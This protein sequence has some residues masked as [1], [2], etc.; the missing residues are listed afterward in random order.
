MAGFITELKRRNVFR[1]A[2]LYI[3]GAWLILQIADVMLPLFELPEWGVRATASILALGFI[4]A[5]I[6]SWIY[7]FT[8]KGLVKEAD[9]ELGSSVTADSGRKIDRITIAALMSVIALLLADRFWPDE[10]RGDETVFVAPE[11][12]AV[13]GSGTEFTP[14]VDQ[15]IPDQ[16]VAVL[17]F[18]NMSADAAN[19][20]FA[21]GLS[22]TLLHELAQISALKVPA[23]T[24][25]FA[26]KGQD[27]DV[28][29]IGRL[30]GVATVLEGSVQKS[31]NQV[32]VIVQLVN[33]TDGSHMWSKNFD[34]DME[35]I[36]AIQDEIALEVC[37]ALSVTLL[38]SDRHRL[39]D[40][41]TVNLDAYEALILGQQQVVLRTAESLAIAEDHFRRAID[42]DPEY[43]RAYVGLGTAYQ[44]QIEYAD[45]P[46]GDAAELSEPMARKAIELDPE[47][48]DAHA[49]L[50]I[51]LS[52][53]RKQ[54]EAE[55]ALVR[56]IEL[57]PNL[58]T[59]YHWYSL[60]LATDTRFEEALQVIR[61][62][63]ELDPL[64]DIIQQNV[65]SRL[66]QNGRVEEAIAVL[67]KNIERNPDFPNYFI[68][69]GVIQ[70]FTLGRLDQAMRSF[71]QYHQ[72]N[73][74]NINTRSLICNTW[75]ALNDDLK[76]ESC[77]KELLELA[78]EK[79]G[80][81]FN[82]AQMAVLKS[83]LETANRIVSSI[84]ELNPGLPGALR[85]RSAIRATMGDYQGAL[86]DLQVS[87]PLLFDP[88]GPQVDARNFGVS[89]VVGYV[90]RQQGDL[91]RSDAFFDRSLQVMASLHRT[92]GQGYG[93]LDMIVYAIRGE[94]DKALVALREAID[95]G[96]RNNWRLLSIMPQLET[97]RQQ[98]EFQSM[99]AELE[100]DMLTQRMRLDSDGNAAVL[101]K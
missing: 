55:A 40:T 67:R 3:V 59:A 97:I 62:A 58:A 75:A 78:P 41:R 8:P 14:P 5:M 46:I 30:L 66:T 47:L 57:N 100:A 11:A 95:A 26:F 10:I 25:S 34:R 39:E 87:D 44:L 18:V 64:S 21:D 74:G 96:W 89:V 19:E 35:D 9:I 76:A 71:E 61:K 60:V 56:A 98:P 80:P 12:P 37:S 65:A 2:A 53:Q 4:P 101:M 82:M 85:F 43:A 28:R 84:L 22:E 1:I 92:R 29:E 91:A 99:L 51:L 42:L 24:S 36:F 31:G 88:H 48:A 49:L 13:V 73:P 79:L 83:D 27:M 72:R 70:R 33:T 54:D 17:P 23:R 68:E 93:V 32:R 77:L 38:D 6:F 16:S 7:E 81:R 15:V 45:R 94:N 69:M 63:E 50:G 52:S 20:H 86:A 90:L